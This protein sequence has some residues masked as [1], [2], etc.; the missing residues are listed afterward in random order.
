MIKRLLATVKYS[1][2]HYF[3]YRLKSQIIRSSVI[4]K[5]CCL[6]F[7]FI[8][9]TNKPESPSYSSF[10]ESFF[11]CSWGDEMLMVSHD[12]GNHS[13]APKTGQSAERPIKGAE[14]T[15]WPWSDDTA[16]SP[17]NIRA[18]T[19]APVQKKA[20]CLLALSPVFVYFSSDFWLILCS[21]VTTANRVKVCREVQSDR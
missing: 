4:K 6:L 10:V 13:A 3:D 1:N 2:N 21:R 5:Q 19:W 8:K 16:R 15:D 17:E 18:W 9:K 14:N 20:F 7:F 12:S 11:F